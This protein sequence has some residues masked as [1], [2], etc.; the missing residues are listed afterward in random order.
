[1]IRR[2]LLVRVGCVGSC[3]FFLSSWRGIRFFW[4]ECADQR[5]SIKEFCEATM[6]VYMFDREG[7]FHVLTVEQVSFFLEREKKNV[8]CAVVG[9]EFSRGHKLG[10]WML[11][12]VGAGS[13][14]LTVV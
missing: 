1:M 13:V 5:D 9:S 7:N 11:A 12:G 10:Y 6:P 14:V 3:E 8:N 2:V 4:G